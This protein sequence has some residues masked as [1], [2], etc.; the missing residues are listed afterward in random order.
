MYT[1]TVTIICA[2]VTCMGGVPLIFKRRL[3][4]EQIG[5]RAPMWS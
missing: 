5:Y 1:A 3:P 2:T 4:L